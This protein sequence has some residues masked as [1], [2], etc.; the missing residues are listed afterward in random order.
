LEL[1]RRLPGQP[2]S[3]SRKV[4]FITGA[5]RGIG[6]AI[7]LRASANHDTALFARDKQKLD[8]TAGLMKGKRLV[9]PGDAKNEEDIRAAVSRALKEF[10][11]IDVLVNNAGFGLFKRVDEFSLAEFEEIWRVNVAGAFLFTKY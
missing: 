11:R 7:A 8:E 10:G 5:S 2:W 6:R 4:I 3:M 1:T 9:L